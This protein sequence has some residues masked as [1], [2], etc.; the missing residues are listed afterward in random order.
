MPIAAEGDRL[1]PVP[2]KVAVWLGREALWSGTLSVGSSPARLSLNEAVETKGDCALPSYRANA[3]TIEVT[4]SRQAYR[5]K[6]GFALTARYSRPAQDGLC[7]TG[8][9]QVSLDQLLSLSDGSVTVEGDGGF[10]VTL[11]R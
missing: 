3:R 9:R 5:V 6:D 4:L 2:V 1:S 8:T 11:T 7:P 10:R